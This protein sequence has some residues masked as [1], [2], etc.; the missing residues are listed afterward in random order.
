MRNFYSGDQVP[1]FPDHVY[2]HKCYCRPLIGC[3]EREGG[4]VI[5][6]YGHRGRLKRWLSEMFPGNDGIWIANQQ[7]AR[8][9]RLGEPRPLVVILIRGHI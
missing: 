3:V 4:R 5:S 8:Y 1:S 2:V 7:A 9:D 6:L